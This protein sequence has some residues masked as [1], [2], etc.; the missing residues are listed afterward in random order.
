[1]VKSQI[2]FLCHK[3]KLWKNN[4]CHANHID[5]DAPFF[6]NNDELVERYFN[7]RLAFI[8]HKFVSCR[9]RMQPSPYRFFLPLLS[10][11]PSPTLTTA[12]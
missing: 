7:Y 4:F 10:S 9:L 6:I 2:K 11:P 12:A 3:K 5:F 8:R 1:M